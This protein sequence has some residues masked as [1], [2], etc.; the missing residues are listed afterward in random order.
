MK[1]IFY[2]FILAFIFNLIWENLHFVLYTQYQGGEITRLILFRSALFD[3]SMIS[4]FG[5]LFISFSFLRQRLWLV[6][7]LATLFAIGL[8]IFAL[9]T[10]RWG[11]EDM[12]PIIPI[13]NVGLSPT[14][15]LG[16][17]T[18]FSFKLTKL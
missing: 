18:Y 1:K 7:T 6:L 16:L 12:M 13:L 11:Y 4:L 8:E 10:G 5:I 17:L 9:Q 14:V 2:V 15:Q 3:A